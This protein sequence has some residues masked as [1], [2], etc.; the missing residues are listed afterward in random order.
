MLAES[1]TNLTGS[2]TSHLHALSG[3]TIQYL[4]VYKASIVDLSN[5]MEDAIQLMSTFIQECDHLETNLESIVVL[6]Q[7]IKSLKT[8][9]DL[10]DK[11][12]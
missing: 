8:K 9:V 2:L 10:L 4:E 12:C 11:L 5:E 7:E 3:I 6:S 1:F